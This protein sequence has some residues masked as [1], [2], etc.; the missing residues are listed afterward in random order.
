[1]GFVHHWRAMYLRCASVVAF[2]YMG[3]YIKCSTFTFF[4][5][6]RIHK[7]INLMHTSISLTIQNTARDHSPA[8]HHC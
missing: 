8:T 2:V 6:Q 4:T 3:R 1:L 5:R 7:Q